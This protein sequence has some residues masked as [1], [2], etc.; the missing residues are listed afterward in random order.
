[1]KY[2]GVIQKLL[3]EL[4]QILQKATTRINELKKS[5]YKITHSFIRQKN[6]AAAEIKLKREIFLLQKYQTEIIVLHN[7]QMIEFHEKK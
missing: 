6:A 1:M 7:R 2:K 5:R 4:H 3:D